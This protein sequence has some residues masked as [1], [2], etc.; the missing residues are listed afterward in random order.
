M[1]FTQNGTFLILNECVT[2]KIA[3]NLKHLFEMNAYFK[4]ANV[5]LLVQN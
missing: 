3:V 4:E 5:G 1:P 2:L